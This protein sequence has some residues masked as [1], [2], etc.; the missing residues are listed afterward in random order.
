[1]KKAP[2]DP[3]A[4]A[5]EVL[6]IESRAVAALVDRID[7]KF[8]QAVELLFGCKGRVVVTGLGKSGIICRKI[9]ATLAS[10]GTPALFMHP[11][12][13]IHGDLGMVVPGDVVLA[14][15]NSGETG[16]L[17]QL[18]ER[19]KRLDVRIIAMTG[20]PGSTLA[21]Q[22]DVHL[23]IGV[24]EEACPMD[25]APTAST[26]ASLAMGDALAMTLVNKRGFSASDFASLHPGGRL[27]RKVLL[28]EKVMHFGDAMPSVTADTLVKDAIYIMSAKRLGLTTVLDSSGRLAGIITDGD[29]RRLMEK[30][31]DPLRQRAADVMTKSP[32]TIA[33]T[34]MAATALSLMEQK[35]ITSLVVVDA[36]R[37]ALGVVH[38]H[39][40]WRTQLI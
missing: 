15:S 24:S 30:V 38:L 10:T 34:E 20:N 25:L 3:L 29:L 6:A 28:V 21:A 36:D 17:L 35:H 26:T 11:A 4:I 18:L 22:S 7:G 40:L 19:I 13:A 12:E 37:R 2:G 39:D 31:P 16:E 1:V 9:A 33:P 8:L 27:G 5:K 32:V 14:V 23:H